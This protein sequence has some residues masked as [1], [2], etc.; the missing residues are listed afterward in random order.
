MEYQETYHG[1]KFVITTLQ[2]STGE[3]ESK[4]ELLDSERRSPLGESS[5]KR[6]PSEEEARSAALST[7]AGAIDQSRISRG[8]P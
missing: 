8:K 6:Y 4:A 3:W 5:G 7:A 2:L 1:Q